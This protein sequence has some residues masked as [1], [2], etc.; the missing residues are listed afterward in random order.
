[1]SDDQAA[2]QE[3]TG[4]AQ[5]R[6]RSVPYPIILIAL[7]QFFKGGFLFYLF[8]QF[9]HGYSGWAASGRPASPFLQDFVDKPFIILFPVLSVVFVV[10]G[11]GLLALQDWARKLLI[12]AII[13]TWIR[14]RFSLD[15]LFFSN[16]ADLRHQHFQV[17][18]CVFLLDLFV[19]GSLVF[20][21]DIA[22]TFGEKEDESLL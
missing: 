19:F 22:K 18:V 12:V 21:P 11:W 9:W 16:S 7:F 17:L 15:A 5:L 13:C 14:G 3:T 10:I 2:G 1:L 6:T 8:F 20:Y 4:N